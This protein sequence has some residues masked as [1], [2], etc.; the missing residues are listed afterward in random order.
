ME[1]HIVHM[2]EIRNV[3]KILEN[4]KIGDQLGVLG[5]DR[6]LMVK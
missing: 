4:L 1:G 5:I 3:Y 6:R 2:S